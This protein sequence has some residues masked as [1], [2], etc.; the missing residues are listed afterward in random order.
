M[1][2][3]NL[4]L[5]PITQLSV[6]NGVHTFSNGHVRIYDPND[7]SLFFDADIAHIIADTN[8]VV[9]T[10]NGDLINITFGVGTGS[11]MVDNWA[12]DLMSGGSM[13]FFFD[14]NIFAATNSFTTD[15]VYR[16]AIDISSVVPEP[17]TLALLGAGLLCTIPILRRRTRNR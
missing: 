6:Q 1:F 4:L 12:N 5:S 15:A 10:M 7:T 11:T 8:G 16:G 9:P 14:S 3:N 17:G 2:G 13:K